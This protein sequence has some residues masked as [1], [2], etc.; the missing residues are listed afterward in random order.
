MR[1]SKK[2]LVVDFKSRM[3]E[4]LVPPLGFISI[5]CADATKA[6]KIESKISVFFIT[7][8]FLLFICNLIKI[9]HFDTKIDVCKSANKRFVLFNSKYGNISLRHFRSSKR[10][11]QNGSIA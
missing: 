4:A 9:R 2:P 7:A 8:G 11:K 3:A 6:V 10:L 5:D 1:G